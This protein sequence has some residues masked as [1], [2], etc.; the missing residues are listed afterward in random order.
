M[1]SSAHVRRVSLVVLMVSTTLGLFVTPSSAK[2]PV[3]STGSWSA[4]LAVSGINQPD[5]TRGVQLGDV[6]IN[7]SGL[8]IAAWDQ[9]TY[10]A[11]GSA[12]IGV[13]VRS[14]GRWGA[15]FT[16]SSGVGF[17]MTPR[18]A[19]GN[20]GTLAVS[21]VEQ[22]SSVSPAVDR[23]Q[24]AVRPAGSSTWTTTTL[25]TFTPTGVAITRSAP[26]GID[27]AGNL[28]AAWNIVSSGRNVVQSARK[29]ANGAWEPV[30]S[31][32]GAA[33]DALYLSLSVNARGD[34]G[35]A[36]T[37]SPYSSY[38]T[39]TWAEYVTRPAWSG[40]WSAPV[41]VSETISS[42]VGYVTNP[43]V[44]LDANGLAT[45]TW[46]GYGLEAARQLS[47]S[48]WTSPVSVITSPV[49]GA[50]FISPDL[51][52]D[53]LGNAVVTVAIF[54]PTINVDRSSVWVSRGT[55]AG[56]WTGPVRLTDPT[57]PVDAYAT[58]VAMSPGGGLAVVGWID[59]Y[60][61]TVQ[62]SRFVGGTWAAATTIGK[63]T[64]WASFQE[65]LVLDA[66]SDTTAVALWKNAK[67]GTQWMTSVFTG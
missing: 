12:S 57:V 11:G 37:I 64:A 67:T 28:F 56:A 44:A 49:P 1:L 22:D 6:A 48:A 33:T 30:V 17:S 55:P 61:G 34:A 62:V 58:Q 54:D 46:F 51:A 53:G 27:A 35:V 36:Y 50:S 32:S 25:A 26:L 65:I 39:G 29:P 3:K 45:V 10:N 31:L 15:P 14:A 20:D 7:T 23:V 5:P 42:S 13:A 16:I 2:P 21:W 52:V 59:H 24:V 47:A 66:A 41:T 18:V 19:A 9:F 63:G 40:V 38:L 4:Q 60:H 43:D 8:A